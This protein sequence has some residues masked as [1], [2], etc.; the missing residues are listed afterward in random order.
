MEQEQNSA[1][2]HKPV[3]QIFSQKQ[4]EE[5]FE[6]LWNLYPRKLGKLKALRGYMKARKNGASYD[7]IK[8]GIERYIKYV[9][10]YDI[11]PLFIMHGSTWFC[12]ER[13]RDE[14][15]EFN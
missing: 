1:D 10:F 7:E 6:S 5:E 3:Q 13:W 11:S 4:Y 8:T 14:Y 2:I 15:Q 9:A 12:A